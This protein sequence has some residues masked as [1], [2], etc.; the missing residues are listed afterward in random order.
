MARWLSGGLLSGLALVTA[1]TAATACGADPEIG[2]PG[3]PSSL[4]G[5][6]GAAGTAAEATA[7]VS[8]DL[9]TA[10]ALSPREQQELFVV[11]SPPAAHTVR[12][13]LLDARD[14][15]LDRSS[16]VTDT[17]GRAAVGLTAPSTVGAFSVRAQVDGSTADLA[18]SVSARALTTV[19]VVPTY[20]G[21]RAIA[22]WVASIHVGRYCTDFE[23]ILPD[24]TA[25]VRFLPDQTARIAKIPLGP[26]LAVT[27][28]AGQFAGGCTE[29]AS[30]GTNEKLRIEVPVYDR[31]LDLEATELEVAF[32]VHESDTAFQSSLE[33]GVRRA[34]EAFRAGASTDLVALLDAMELGLT[35]RS[36]TEFS[37]ARQEAGWDAA[38]V[39][40]PAYDAAQALTPTITRWIEVGKGSLLGARAFEGRLSRGPSF[41]IDRI[42]QIAAE[43]VEM[44]AEMASWIGNV[45]DELSFTGVFRWEHAR[46]VTELAIG[47]AM[48]E[49]GALDVPAALSV[50]AG[51][52][53]FGQTLTSTTGAAVAALS[54]SCGAVCLSSVCKTALTSMWSRA[55]SASSGTAELTIAAAGPASIG[56]QAQVID[57]AG[58]WVGKLL[59]EDEARETGGAVRG[60][61][62]RYTAR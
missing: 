20:A 4:G 24:S 56:E 53:Q 32:G 10:L 55:A 17:Q 3:P 2:R 1:S 31:A 37:A 9:P 49:T 39:G 7:I 47:P 62:P 16:V 51:C 35:G 26:E 12:F 41:V 46:L 61:A 22:E 60:T 42:G 44:Q 40:V 27:V 58:N 11:V 54:A 29:V 50:V 52:D 33:L 34:T 14:A 30:G 15:A 18:L 21:R 5:Q 36:R 6:P 48:A 43:R 45:S 23:G 28:R 38:V 8:F 59:L 13:A 25:Y 57:F 19:E